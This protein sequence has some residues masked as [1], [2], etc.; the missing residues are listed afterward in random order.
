M[1]F[2][3][4]LLR[5][6]EAKNLDQTQLGEILNLSKSTISAYEKDTRQPS[7]ETIVLIAKY[8]N[9]TTDFLLRG[10]IREQPEIIQ[11]ELHDFFIRVSKLGEEE[12]EFLKKKIDKMITALEEM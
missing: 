3:K 9:V 8:F 2:G 1:S 7:P 12:R 6:R 5:L 4:R 11:E 10:D